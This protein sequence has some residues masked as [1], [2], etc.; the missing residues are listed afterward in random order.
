MTSTALFREKAPGIMS[1][2]MRD[3]DI[4]V[5][6]AAAIVGNLGHE[7]GGFKFLQEKKPLVPGSRGGWGWAQWTGPRRRQF[8]DFVRE[9]GLDPAGD[10]ANLG[11]LIFE[12][13]GP[14]KAAVPATERA[15]GLRAKVEAFEKSFER[16]GVKHYPSR[17]KWA[18]LALAAYEGRIDQAASAA[19]DEVVTG[20]PK[21][22]VIRVAGKPATAP[23]RLAKREW[24]EDTLQRYEVEAIQKRLREL[25]YFMVGKVD[26]QWGAAT[27]AAITA[28]QTDRGITI[29]GHYGPQTRDEL[30]KD[31]K[32]PISEA[33]KNTTVEDL[34]Q[35]GSQ[36]IH[37]QDR[38]EQ[39]S[40]AGK[41]LSTAGLLFGFV[42]QNISE[43]VGWARPVADLF[44]AVWWV[45][46][47][48]ALAACV[49]IGWK[50]HATKQARL[51]A[52]H[53]GLHNGEPDPA[54][55]PPVEHV[56]HREAA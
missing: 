13:R 18:E 52:E 49:Y 39:V 9:R 8:E 54:P 26:G 7:S 33:R 37:Q 38:I 5:E 10:E 32:R 23:S 42:Y 47:L 35:Q 3:L 22:F 1:A 25:G 27:R 2:L 16:A 45:L 24:S 31:I 55:S 36:T 28:L 56:E 17:M 21:K 48:L 12:L 29:D 34:R 11:F 15:T 46:P 44:G 40:L 14:E 19:L 50:T 51:E 43:A 20:K 4:S 30:A 53:L 6:D 41:V